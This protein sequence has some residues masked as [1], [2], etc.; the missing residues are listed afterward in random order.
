MK[1]WAGLVL[2]VLLMQVPAH[3]QGLRRVA[4]MADGAPAFE[5]LDARGQRIGRIECVFNGWYDS[6]AMAIR[7]L[8]SQKLLA[9]VLAKGARL[10]PED[11]GPATFDCVAVPLL[12]P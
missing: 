7:V 6:D 8:G 3:A 9:N 1:A 5:I 12:R 4:N 2:L 11:L 10:A